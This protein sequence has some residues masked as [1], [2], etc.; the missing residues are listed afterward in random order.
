MQASQCV[1]GRVFDVSHPISLNLAVI[2]NNFNLNQSPPEANSPTLAG[3]KFSSICLNVNKMEFKISDLEEYDLRG[4]V[5]G[6][7]S[8]QFFRF[9]SE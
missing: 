6:L 1:G 8:R 5:I 2:T 3:D 7:S 9:G 4:K